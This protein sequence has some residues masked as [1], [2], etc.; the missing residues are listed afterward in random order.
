MDISQF[1][2]R[3]AAPVTESGCWIWLGNT[4]CGYGTVN[5]G[6][7]TRRANRVAFELANGEIPDGAIICHRCDVREC[8]NPAHLYAGTHADNA[9]DAMLRKRLPSGDQHW[10]KRSPEKIARGDRQGTHTKPWTRSRGE[11]HGM[12]KLT[13]ADVIA[14]R[15]DVRHR[16]AIASSYG[17]AKTY[18]NQIKARSTWKHLP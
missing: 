14:I 11:A 12:S 16:G 10:M 4:V 5:L 9:R 7:R 18:V 1:L 8:V 13:A 3:Y 2:E 15:S 6:D 17:I